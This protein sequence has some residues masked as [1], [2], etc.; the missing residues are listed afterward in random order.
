MRALIGHP[1]IGWISCGTSAQTHG[2][3]C[4]DGLSQFAL[5]VSSMMVIIASD[6][7]H[8]LTWLTPKCIIR[9]RNISLCRIAISMSWPRLN[10]T[11]R[12]H[13]IVS[14]GSSRNFRPLF[15]L[16]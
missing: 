15:F 2:L 9:S 14:Q 6:L 16:S 1:S 7:I 5:K 11:G 12:K 8:C 13:F 4:V 10:P 3:S